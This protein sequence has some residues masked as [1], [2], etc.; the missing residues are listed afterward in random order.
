MAIGDFYGLWEVVGE[1]YKN[2]N[3][4]IYVPCECA[5]GERRSVRK[6]NLISGKSH[7]CGGDCLA[8]IDKKASAMPIEEINTVDR[9]IKVFKNDMTFVPEP[10]TEPTHYPPGS[11]GKIEVMRRRLQNGEAL[12]H[13]NDASDCTNMPTAFH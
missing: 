2:F 9:W 1:E 4:A 13:P 11:S 10:A 7:R 3:N 12:F 8:Y 6:H 5:C